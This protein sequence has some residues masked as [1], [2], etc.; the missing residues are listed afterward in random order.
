[1]CSTSARSARPTA[2]RPWSRSRAAIRTTSGSIPTTRTTSSTR[3]T[4]GGPCRSTR[5][6]RSGRGPRA[7]IRRVSSTMWPRPDTCRIT[8]AA[9]SRTA[10][11]SASRA[12]RA[13][14]V[15]DAAAVAVAAAAA[16]ATYGAGGAEPG[17]I[18][19]DPKDL[20]VFFA[21]GNNG[22]FLTR[23]NRKTGE[24]REVGPYPRMFSGEPSS[25]LVERWQWTFPII[26]S[27]VDP[28]VLYTSS[29]H[30]WRT[31]NGGQTWDKISRRSH[32]PRSENDGRVR[33]TDHQGHERAGGLR[34]RLRDR[35]GQEGRQHHLGRIGRRARA[36]DA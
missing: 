11:R 26:F 24:T 6:R 13:S 7:T 29:Q 3:T 2:A 12:T 17:Y 1:M 33:R 5:Q 32:A 34:H 9:R 31:T 22:S 23:L 19:P 16:P 15:V 35:A 20:D 25:A 21:G 27:P 8:S 14:A 4:S 28:N 10:A 30:V 18:A 36:R